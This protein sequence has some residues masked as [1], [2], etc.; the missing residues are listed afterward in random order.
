MNSKAPLQ[1]RTWNPFTQ[2]GALLNFLI[3][4]VILISFSVAPLSIHSQNSKDPFNIEQLAEIQKPQQVTLISEQELPIGQL[5]KGQHVFNLKTNSI[6]K[7]RNNYHELISSEIPDGNGKTHK[8]LYTEYDFFSPDFEINLLKENQIIKLNNVDRGLHLK[9]IQKNNSNSISSLSIFENELYGSAYNSNG[10]KINITPTS[11]SEYLATQCLITDE[12]LVDFSNLKFECNTDDFRHYIGSE[13]SVSTRLN[14]N[15]KSV[16]I[17]IDV[18]Y[19]LYLKFK[20]N[21][22]SISNYVTGLFNNVHTLYKKEA[23][24]IALSQINIHATDDRFTHRTASEDLEFFRT[25]YPN[26]KKTIKLLLSGY[27]KNKIASL[28][29]ISYINTLCTPSYSYAFVNVN[30][31][32]ENYSIY[33]WD[34]FATTHELGHIMG[35]RHTHACVWGPKNNVALDNCAKVEGSCGNPGIPKKGTIMSY[36]FQTGMPG[37][38]FLLGFGTEPGNL[39]R[40]KIASSKCLSS[41][42]PVAKTISNPNSKIEANVECFDGVYTHYYFDNNTI[43]PTDDVLILSINKKSNDIGNLTDGSLKIAL[44]TTKDYSEYKLTPITALYVNPLTSWNVL[45]KFW[46]IESNKTPKT[47]VSLVYYFGANDINAFTTSKL[48][49]G[50]NDLNMYMLS[51]STNP[52]PS[53]NHAGATKDAAVLIGSAS[54]MSGGFTYSKMDSTLYSVEVNSSFLGS[55]GIG[56]SVNLTDA[57]KFTQLSAAYSGGYH[58]TSFTASGE[59]NIVRYVIER[60][61]DQIHFDSIGMLTYK[62]PSST[63]NVYKHSRLGSEEKEFIYRIRAVTKTNQWTYSAQFSQNNPYDGTNGLSAY[64][65]PVK[66]GTLYIDYTNKAA[67]QSATITI[68]DIYGR[69][70]KNYKTDILSGKNT[71]NISTLELPEGLNYLNLS[72]KTENLKISFSVRK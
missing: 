48:A 67:A 46:T 34:V 71:L 43:D 39:I 16:L 53:S 3:I 12:N 28:G 65:N 25:R 52:S 13:F 45:N 10:L 57:V 1:L 2:S 29:G 36:C 7:L 35:S 41:Y 8:F 69:V 49:N 64:P 61:A 30:G 51:N 4:P 9:G 21:V 33:S 18:D 59:N 66:T 63:N 70:L 31:T 54:K 20:G 11:S 5:Q 23:I 44:N 26:T 15:C 50:I 38:D 42:T 62:K 58:T 72:T 47:S 56:V 68:N 27:E 24:S 14:D 19:A 55:S 60:S 32:Y 37:I 40:S 22:Q 17:S 6:S